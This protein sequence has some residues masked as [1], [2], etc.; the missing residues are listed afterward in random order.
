M[1]FKGMKQC[2]HLCGGEESEDVWAGGA[3]DLVG[4]VGPFQDL[5]RLLEVGEALRGQ[6]RFTAR[7]TPDGPTIK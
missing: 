5:E 3:D 2:L 1:S 6:G 7:C 4:E